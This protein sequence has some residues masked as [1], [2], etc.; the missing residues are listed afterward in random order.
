MSKR[1][2]TA[3]EKIL[4]REI[5]KFTRVAVPEIKVPLDDVV[6]VTPPAPVEG[7]MRGLN[8]PSPSLA[9]K[10]KVRTPK[11]ALPAR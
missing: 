1:L 10:E 7:A 11:A 8:A 3:E 5:N 4:W 9:Q 6:N 2:P